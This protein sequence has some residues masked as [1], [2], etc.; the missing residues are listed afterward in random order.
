MAFFRQAGVQ[1]LSVATSDGKDFK[2]SAAYN[3]KS[4]YFEGTQKID[5]QA[6]LDLVANEYNISADPKDYIFE[7]IRGNTSNVRNENKDAFHKTELLRFDH[8]LGKQVY[9]TYQYK[10]HQIQHRADNPKT[11]RGFILD[12][13]YN[14]RSP[15]SAECENCHAK[16]A[17]KEARDAETGLHCIK[18]GHVVKDEFVELLVAI[19]TKKDPVF[20]NGVMSG[21]LRHGSM[22]CSCA[23]T[24]CNVCNHVASTAS[25]FCKHI[26]NKGKVYAEGAEDFNPVAY[27]IKYVNID[28][29]NGR[30]ASSMKEAEAFEWCEGVVFE[31]YSR[32]QDPADPKAEQYEILKLSASV[33]EASNN[34]LAQESEL[35]ILKSKVAALEKSMS[36]AAQVQDK[37][38][39]CP[40]CAEGRMARWEDADPMCDGDTY[41]RCE[42]CAELTPAAKETGGHKEADV[43]VN[44]GDGTDG[45]DIKSTD[46]IED[47]QGTSIEDLSPSDVGLTPAEEGEQLTPAAMGIVT[48]KPTESV[49]APPKRGG[50]ALSNDVKTTTKKR[51]VS[52]KF[53][54]ASVYK[55]LTISTTKSGNL[56]VSDSTGTLFVMPVDPTSKSATTNDDILASIQT[57]GLTTTMQKFKAVPSLHLAQVLD[58]AVDDML[59]AD[60][61]ETNSTHEERDE[62]MTDDRQDGEVLESATESGEHTDT[63]EHHEEKDLKDDALEGREVDVEDEKHDKDPHALNVTKDRDFDTR[64]KRKDFDL[65]ESVLDG[66]AHD[67]QGKVAAVEHEKHIARLTKLYD[68]RLAEQATALKTQHKAEM[69]MLQNRLVRALKFVARRQAMNIEHSPLK[70][71]FGIVLANGRDLGQGYEYVPMDQHTAVSL[72]ETAFGEKVASSKPTW[73][74][75]IDG[76]FERAASVMQMSDEALMQV[77]SDM[78]NIRTASVVIEYQPEPTHDESVR[79]A[80]RAGNMTVAP[81]DNSDDTPRDTRAASIREAIG[82]MKVGNLAQNTK[83]FKF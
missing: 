28:D 58:K 22:G 67:H 1:V 83:N 71:A 75:F 40:E 34:T 79:Q 51:I 2:K 30:T 27:T 57:N 69:D 3:G 6:A 39:L 7:A 12:A 63:E 56:A 50:S 38:I 70:E 72:I 77:E 25:E 45:V 61:Q 42:G 13:T 21:V 49:N 73:E 5:V 68:T 36:K 17:A 31:E 24:R 18:C 52:S 19:D 78:N 11:A 55:E 23:R 15:A 29:A 60:R 76:L 48:N 41:T 65:S 10:P 20:A 16:T 59:D 47:E 46:P 8:R 62:T 74:A 43:I 54:G 64:E 32:V 66:E 14:D 44:I 81:V 4:A 35:L 80:A 82:G 9:R 26:R 33:K 37:P 53:K